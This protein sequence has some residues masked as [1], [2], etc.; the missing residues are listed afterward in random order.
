MQELEKLLGVKHHVA[1]TNKKASNPL[2]RIIVTRKQIGMEYSLKIKGVNRVVVTRDKD[3]I[4]NSPPLELLSK[5][6][7][8]KV[9]PLEGSAIIRTIVKVVDID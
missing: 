1:T 8:R 9:S 4:F 3:Y 2:H 5:M 7:G 6:M